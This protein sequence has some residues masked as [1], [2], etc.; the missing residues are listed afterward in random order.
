[1]DG[2]RRV[3]PWYAH[4]VKEER[5]CAMGMPTRFSLDYP[6]RCLQLI[7]SFED[8]ARSQDMV[9]SFS[10]L[11][12][13]SVL[14]V[15][16]ERSFTTHPLYRE[17]DDPLTLAI[18]VLSKMRFVDAAFWRD[19]PPS[20]WRQSRLLANFNNPE[21]WVDKDGK[22]PFETD[23]DNSIGRRK[24][25][26]V[27][28]VLRNALAHGNIVYLDENGQE[29]EGAKVRFLAFLSR[30]EETEDQKAE[31]ETYRMVAATEEE[32]L[33][34]VKAWAGWLATLHHDGQIAAE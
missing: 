24:A 7:N 12:A 13:S 28:R 21:Y 3:C 5:N 25:L 6:Q 22:H 20:D 17:K 15:P 26:E 29:R 10:L 8:S 14:N 19:V 4:L 11:A 33:R 23:A 34:F 31:S 9:G 16:L 32:F 30:Y 18:K 1:M 2:E 27:L